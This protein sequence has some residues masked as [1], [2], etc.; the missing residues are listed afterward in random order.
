MTSRAELLAELEKKRWE[1]NSIEREPIELSLDEPE[2][3]G[4]Y[5]PYDNPGLGKEIPDGVDIAARRRAMVTGNRR[6]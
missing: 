4:G 5:D 1:N 6:R 2:A 3:V